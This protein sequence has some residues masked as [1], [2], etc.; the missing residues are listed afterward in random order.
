M[1][2]S[3]SVLARQSV[4]VFFYTVLG[5]ISLLSSAQSSEKINHTQSIEVIEDKTWVKKEEVEKTKVYNNGIKE[6]ITINK[7]T[8]HISID[9]RRVRA[10]PKP[11]KKLKP[12]KKTKVDKKEIGPA[13]IAM[14]KKKPIDNEVYST[15]KND[16]SQPTIKRV[17]NNQ[18]L[19]DEMIGA[20]LKNSPPISPETG[21]E[22]KNAITQAV[23]GNIER[24]VTGVGGAGVVKE[25]IGL[26]SGGQSSVLPSAM[27]KINSSPF[28]LSRSKLA[29]K[30][31]KRKRLARQKI[32]TEYERGREKRVAKEQKNHIRKINQ[33][34]KSIAYTC[35]SEGKRI[36]M[37]VNV[38]EQ[39]GQQ[40]CEML[41]F[42]SNSFKPI[43]IGE[44][45]SSQCDAQAK[46]WLDKQ[47]AWGWQCD[48]V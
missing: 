15:P 48:S 40:V 18:D 20:L 31:E 22:D 3:K 14:Q 8:G 19:I 21:S 43:N 42:K 33:V 36:K 35:R 47:K 27:T 32:Q 17:A 37:E 1:N 12:R 10:K 24:N 11:K 41:Y 2:C 45:Q 6:T 23:A 34:Y 5:G 25:K 46:R 29:R 26:D 28:A 9:M 16:T 13:N 39:R 44:F 30:I 4:I 7:A 38:N